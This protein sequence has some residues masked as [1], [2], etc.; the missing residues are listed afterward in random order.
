MPR[1]IPSPQRP[2]FLSSRYYGNIHAIKQSGC[3]AKLKEVYSSVHVL[4]LHQSHKTSWQELWSCR[5]ALPAEKRK[6][7][8]YSCKEREIWVLH[9]DPGAGNLG[10]QKT[11]QEAAYE[12]ELTLALLFVSIRRLQNLTTEADCKWETTHKETTSQVTLRVVRP[13]TV[14]VRCAGCLHQPTIECNMLS[15][16]EFARHNCSWNTFP[17]VY[18]HDQ[19]NAYVAWHAKQCS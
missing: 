15:L 17:T 10:R 7:S 11:S 9:E 13:K 5:Q 14:Q 16:P 1:S 18:A 12:I 4:Q 19:W 6:N 8:L 3:S 2:E